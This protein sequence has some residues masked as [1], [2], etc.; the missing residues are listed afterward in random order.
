MSKVLLQV[1][2]LSKAY[3]AKQILKEASV[4]ILEKQKIGV[5]GRNGAGKTTFFKMILGKEEPD[6]GSIVKMP[7]LR[8]GYIEQHDPFE[9]GE[10]VLGFLERYTG[11]PDWECSK[12]ASKFEL[13]GEKLTGLISSLSGGYQ[14]RVK[15]TATLLFEPN[16]L[17]LDEPT[18][19]LDLTTLILLEKFLLSFRGGFMVIT[20][21]REFLKKTCDATLDVEGGQLF[22][23][24]EGLE[25]YLEYKKEQKALA[26]SVNT[27]IERKQKQLQAFVDRFG[28]K[29]SMAKSAQSKIKQIAKMD[30]KKITINN[31]FSA[32]NIYIP[33]V[34]A[35]KGY[36]LEVK[37]LAIGYPNKTVC[38]NINFN[39]ERGQKVAILGDNGQGKSTLIKTIAGLIRPLDGEYA[40]KNNT[41]IAYY[42]QL[43]SQNMDLEQT[44]FGYIKEVAS[45]DCK[46]EERYRVLGNFLFRKE[47]YLKKVGVLSGGEK[48]R[49]CL[50]GMFLTKSDVYLLDEPTNHLDFET[51]EAMGSAL[52]NFNGTVFVVS[53]NR[54]F[55][56]LIANEIIEIQDG[57]LKRLVGTYEDY[58]W[59]LE[60]KLGEVAKNEDKVVGSEAGLENPFEAEFGSGEVKNEASSPAKPKLSGKEGYEL[61]KELSK[62]ERKMSNLQELV[63]GGIDI[64]KN[65]AILNGLEIRWLEI[66]DRL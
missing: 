63:A 34:E 62:I 7:S 59:N 18:N 21:D 31:P 11:K 44:V 30:D 3:G 33:P 50:A 58:V 15:L 54:T 45:E 42:H 53:H 9:E 29:A 1:K 14:M 56:N 40:W 49:L 32:A 28:A 57:I 26:Q 8:I 2:D 61:R 39:I 65:Q 19:Y 5:I 13:K 20:H 22:L 52:R 27:N 24:D 66:K 55:V 48:S 23:H 37:N 41:K 12:V 46:E 10:T 51:V 35:K 16:L 25:E 17:M 4:T 60:Q 64:E 47:D 6:S 43:V 36:I 38:S